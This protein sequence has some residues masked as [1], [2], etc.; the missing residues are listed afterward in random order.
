MTDDFRKW[1]FAILTHLLQYYIFMLYLTPIHFVSLICA[2][3]TRDIEP[4]EEF[5]LDYGEAYTKAFLLPQPKCPNSNISAGVMESELPGGLVEEDERESLNVLD[6]D[7]KGIVKDG[8]SVHIHTNDDVA[9][10][11][12]DSTSSNAI[13]LG[14]TAISIATN[15]NISNSMTSGIE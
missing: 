6:E 2:V 7:C 10:S 15:D 3:A 11:V 13:S 12:I 8:A 1:L 9:V 5:L 14:L 4:G